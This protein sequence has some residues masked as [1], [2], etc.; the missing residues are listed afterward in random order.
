[1]NQT[2]CC[3]T[4]RRSNVTDP[5]SDLTSKHGTYIHEFYKF[6]ASKLCY[7]EAEPLNQMTVK[8][9]TLFTN[10]PLSLNISLVYTLCQ[11]SLIGTLV[12]Q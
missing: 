9:I 4:Y 8:T 5:P 6:Q 7:T 2:P 1:M 12:P 10:F 3:Y 11:D